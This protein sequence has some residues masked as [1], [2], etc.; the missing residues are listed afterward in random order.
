[1]TEYTVTL[2]F[3]ISGTGIFTDFTRISDTCHVLTD[4]GSSG[5]VISRGRQG[6]SGR[7]APQSVSL[8]YIDNEALLYDENGE[9]PYYRQLVEFTPMIITIDDGIGP[10]IRIYAE[11]AAIRVKR[12]EQGNVIISIE[13]AGVKRRLGHGVWQRP[14]RSCA[15]RA[16]S[17]SD[18]DADR[19]FYAP[20]EEASGATSL[21]VFRNQGFASFSGAVTFGGYTAAPSAE[22]MLTF[23]AAGQVE[24][25]IPTYTS[26]M[27]KVCVLFTTPA[28]SLPAGT[29]ILRMYCIGGNVDYID[30]DYGTTADGTLRFLAYKNGSLVDDANFVGWSGHIINR[31]FFISLEFEQNGAN[32]ETGVLIVNSDSELF[33]SDPLTSVTIGRVERIV[34]APEDCNGLSMGQLIVGTDTT[35]FSNYISSIGLDGTAVLG[36]RGFTGEPADDRI[37]RLCQ[38]EGVNEFTISSSQYGGSDGTRLGPQEVKPF[39][40]LLEL[41]AE[42][43]GGVLYESIS[44]DSLIYM[45]RRAMMNQHPQYSATYAMLVPPLLPSRDDSG[46]Q[47]DVTVK[48]TAG[49]NG[50]YTIPD[51]DYLHY[52]TQIPPTGMS[53]VPGSANLNLGDDGDCELQAAWRAHHGSWRGGGRIPSMVY[54]LSKAVIAGNSV[55]LNKMIGLTPGQL[56]YQGTIGA[57]KWL[58]PNHVLGILQGYKESFGQL[59]RE[60]AVSI[61]PGDSWEIKLPDSDASIL[62]NDIDANDIELFVDPGELG[63]SWTLDD[64]FY[65]QINGDVFKVTA[66][67]DETPTFINAGAIASANNGPVTPALPAGITENVGQSLFIWATIR[68]SGTGVPDD[69]AGWTTIAAF[70]NT[71]L[72]HRYYTTG[73][74]APQITFTGGVANAD[75][76]AR[77]FAFSGV[78]RSLCSGTKSAPAAA[79]QLNSSAAN[80]AYPALTLARDG[81][82]M[83]FVWKQDD[84]TGYAPPGSM[85]EMADNSSTAGDDA[86]VAAYYQLSA[87]D[88]AAGSITVTGGAAAI[89]RAIVLAFRPLQSFIVTRDVVSNAT[90]HSAGDAIHAWRQGVT[91]L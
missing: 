62:A 77:M 37:S 43:D 78:S 85:T 40:E 89:S 64:R 20:L 17:A 49:S 23:G 74:T 60:L 46:K 83:M 58:P 39:L 56:I 24:F 15:Y 80:V 63:P 33:N 79:T 65:A 31:H 70:G 68:N 5:I 82:A 27:H 8:E 18:N 25:I 88:F 59:G 90:S 41:A 16:L 66:S 67:F 54:N 42:T 61:T 48:N 9:S 13:G 38:E 55:V 57:T 72:Y 75:C 47:N 32:L 91:G 51:D 10:D 6:M 86:S 22:R 29:A 2:E 53:P 76:L 73:V 50:R 36:T 44:N 7:I 81:T 28:T 19:V 34:G 84:A 30:L 69:E 11:L 3:D 45:T 21:E 12:I 14:L 87:T 1:M 26:T 35:A 71:K 4:K 52:S